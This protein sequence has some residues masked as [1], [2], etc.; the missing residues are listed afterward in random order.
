MDLIKGLNDMQKQ[1]VLC[2]EGP[3]LLLAGA[4]S[5]KTKV[6]TH[7]IAYI[8]EKGTSMENILALT[9]TN[10]AAKEMK[11][12]VFTLLES[13]D[14]WVSTF[15]STC[16]RILRRE[17]HKINYDNSFT[18]YDSD[19]S[20]RLIKECLKELNFNDKM[21]PPKTIINHIG[22][23]KDNLKTPIEFKNES[24]GD[25]R[26]IQI[27][28]V[29]S[30]YQKRL[31]KSN[32]LDF[33]DIIFKT[34][35][36]FRNNLEVLEKYQNKFR[37]I[38]VDEYQDTN[39]AQ[40]ALIKLLASKYKNLCVVGDDDQSIYGWRGANIRNILD[41]ENDFKGAKLIKLEQNYRSTQT[42]LDVANSII[43]NNPGRKDKSLWTENEKGGNV[44]YHKASNDF[45]E[46]IFV[47]DKIKEHI[48]NNGKYSDIAILYRQNALSRIIED[49]L[50]KRNIPYR[51]FGG[52]RFYERREI[53]DLL[54][55][56]KVIYNSSDNIAT[57]RII[58]VPK[59]GIGA[60]TVDKV[61]D[62]A[63]NNGFS[64]FEA[65]NNLEALNMGSRGKKLIDF[66]DLINTFKDYAT[67]NSVADLIKEILNKTEYI[68]E[69]EKEDRDQAQGRIENIHELIS[70][71]VE[72]EKISE[73]KSLT[74]FL[75]EI[76]LVADIDNYEEGDDTIVLMTLHSS[77]GLEFPT[78]FIIGFEENI[79]PGY[80]S[81]TS[82][83]KSDMEEE[84]RLCYVGVTRAKQT[85]YITSARS[86]MQNGKVVHNSPSR[87]L[88]EIPKNLLIDYKELSRTDKPE[89]KSSG[90]SQFAGIKIFNDKVNTGLG[91]KNYKSALPEPKGKKLDFEVGDKV[92]QIKY[93]TGIVK[94][95]SPAGADYEVTVEFE[96]VGM[97]KFMAHLSKLKKV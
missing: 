81:M 55:Y 25:F 64:F 43:K 93:G 14:I 20:E 28:K 74:A 75:E 15:H 29:Y 86:R 3:L 18:I 94:N 92:K 46:A 68:K 78:V 39:T 71:A 70:K 69:L 65:L 16:V 90:I 47:T 7:R 44:I 82:E 53:K 88:K 33:D 32:A 24:Q 54:A 66:K 83:N 34:V 45:E 35:E 76:S 61:T 9:F 10:K 95:I 1:A 50:V 19:D 60:A 77:K 12:R 4:G 23:L 40:Y 36:L 30:L 38:M 62:Y 59:R 57:K 27:A 72:F 51:L 89:K 31:K 91:G 96:S 87:F 58:N 6:I 52:V 63:N 80:R 84:R 41:F 73:D 8:V 67:N 13:G 48:D 85:L 2:T 56:L 26:N 42:I 11:E 79:F 5:G 17:I 97:K 37:Y 22:N 21:F 49:Q